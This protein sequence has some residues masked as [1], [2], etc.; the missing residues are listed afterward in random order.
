MQ[1]KHNY[2]NLSEQKLMKQ[3]IKSVSDF[4]N[5][6]KVAQNSSSQD[7][8]TLQGVN[9]NLFGPQSWIYVNQ[10]M[11]E[12]NIGLYKLAGNQKLGNQKLGNQSVN[13]QSVVRNPTAITRFTGGLKNLFQLS[14]TLWNMVTNQRNN[15]YSIDEAKILVNKLSTALNSADFPEPNSQP[16]KNKLF[17]IL[18]N[19]SSILK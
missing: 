12:L 6:I 16:I 11:N 9:S 15:I 4:S 5:M 13:F 18:N 7:I 3:F 14:L 1:K 8:R 2:W 10:F 19:W 17:T